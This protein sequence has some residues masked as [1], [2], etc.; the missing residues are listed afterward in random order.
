MSSV[1]FNIVLEKVLRR[2]G[3][4]P[5]RFKERLS[6]R[7]SCVAYLAYADDLVFV[8]KSHKGL[9]TLFSYLEE[10]A[11]IISLQIMNTKP[12]TLSLEEKKVQ[13]Y[14]VL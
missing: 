11:K 4:R 6:L 3:I 12:S 7:V 13:E 2:T 1:L 9:R 8:D 10:T 5:P 14:I